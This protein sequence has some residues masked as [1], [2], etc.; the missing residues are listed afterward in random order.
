MSEYVTES[1]LYTFGLSI[2]GPGSLT[3]DP[4][5][6]DLTWKPRCLC[7]GG[8]RDERER[9]RE[10]EREMGERDGRERCVGFGRPLK[11]NLRG[12]TRV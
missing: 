9:E 8:E 1:K 10:R 4:V 6:N 7:G 3:C 2:A 11:L 5:P 12:H